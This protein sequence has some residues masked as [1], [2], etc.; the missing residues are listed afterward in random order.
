MTDYFQVLS[1]PR[2]PWLEQDEVKQ[3]FHDLSRKLHPDHSPESGTSDRSAELN[4]AF[5]VLTDTR[6]RLAHLIE[7]ET[8]QKLGAIQQIPSA[9]VDLAMRAA[10]LAQEADKF[11]Q[12]KRAAT[13]P[14]M[15]A[16]MMAQGMEWSEKLDAL[17]KELEHRRVF[18]EQEL[19]EL[20]GSWETHAVDPTSPLPLPRLE[21][22]YRTISF[23]TR[24]EQQLQDRA[25]QMAF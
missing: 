5:R 8:A 10:Q 9:A 3:R 6:Q 19:C 20:N 25:M 7:L 22:L 21:E 16:Q 4:T 17:R 14:I 23:L 2:L 18:V 24:W 12:A 13:S 1:L 11:L 15:Q